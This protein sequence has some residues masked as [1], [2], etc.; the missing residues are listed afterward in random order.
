MT[1]PERSAE[2]DAALDALT[3]THPFPG[4]TTAALQL[5]AG[6]DADLLFPGGP[7]DMVESWT[8]LADR[9]MQPSPAERLP[10]RVRAIIALRLLTSRT[11]KDAVRRGL[12]VLATDP[13]AAARTLARTIDTVWHVAGD[14]S[15]DWNWYSKRAILAGV[16]ATTLLYWLRDD[17]EEDE[18]TLAFLD[19]R[20]AG[21]GRIGRL[22]GKG[23]GLMKRMRPGSGS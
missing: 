1:A 3:A 9:R 15:V 23:A 7:I 8:D 14:R 13:P 10:A 5:V 17:S 6:P 16:Y 21:V 19:R 22:R 18:A 12:A 20:L 4:W 2:R 11:Q